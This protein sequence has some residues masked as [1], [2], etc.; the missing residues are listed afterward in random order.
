MHLGCIGNN[1]QPIESRV[2]KA[3]QSLH[4][5]LSRIASVTGIDYS[6]DIID[7]YRSLGIY[8]NIL[9]G[10]VQELEKIELNKQFD[11][12]LATDIIEHLSNPG[13]MLE[14]VKRFC[15]PDT[16]IVVTTPNAFGLPNFLRFFM[17][18]YQETAEHVLN[19]NVETLFNLPA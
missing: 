18:K 16:Q 7:A 8:T 5:K 13:L 14:G 6:R 10:D 15:H 2:E 12:I 3:H 9:A 19:F 11:V 17:G 4:W 1:D